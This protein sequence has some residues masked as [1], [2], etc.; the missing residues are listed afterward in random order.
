MNRR[1]GN[2]EESSSHRFWG[3]RTRRVRD[4]DLLPGQIFLGG[5]VQV[6]P[7]QLFHHLV[8]VACFWKMIFSGT[9]VKIY[10]LCF[11]L[12]QFYPKNLT[13]YLELIPN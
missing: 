3:F 4:L 8:D 10:L 6:D 1:W 13:A 7:S 2:L 11:V 5:R 12:F 9:R